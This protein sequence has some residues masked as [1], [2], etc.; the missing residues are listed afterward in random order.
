[1][2]QTLA[3]LQQRLW[4]LVTA[5]DGDRSGADA[6]LRGDPTISASDRL[7]VYANAYFARLHD[8]LRDDF[9]ALA[10]ALGAEAFHDLVKTYLMTNPPTRP[11]LREAGASLPQHLATEPFAGIFARRCEYA[12]DLASLELALAEAFYAPDA[13]AVTHEELAAVPADRWPALRFALAPALRV[14]RCDWPV[15]EIRERCDA[16]QDGAMW[17]AAPALAREPTAVR[18]FR[19][20]ERVRYRVIARD[21][22]EA[23]AAAAAGET[24]AAICECVTAVVGEADAARRSAE[25]LGAWLADGMIAEIAR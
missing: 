22:S 17:P 7:S 2:E 21:E 5:P 14:V 12:A 23:L 19:S 8:A 20:S 4:R 15:H 18:V 16:E 6:L 1:V 24:F 11:S 10:R 3:E 25:L 13:R 9:P